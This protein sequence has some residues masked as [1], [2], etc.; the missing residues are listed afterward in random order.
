MQVLRELGGLAA[1]R[2]PHHHNDLVLTDHLCVCVCVRA[3]VCAR[4]RVWLCEC[5]CVCTCVCVCVRARARMDWH[6]DIQRSY[7]IIIIIISSSSI[8]TISIIIMTRHVGARPTV[9]Q[10]G[11]HTHNLVPP[12]PLS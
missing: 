5:T 4:A 2:L 6:G 10:L 11:K 1:A 3:C 8:I 9:L 7:A 12:S